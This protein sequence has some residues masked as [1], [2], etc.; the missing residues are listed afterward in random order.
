MLET[1][2]NAKHIQT[3]E[4]A[5][6]LSHL[7]QN[8][9][10]ADSCMIEAVD[11]EIGLEL[12]SITR[13]ATALLDPASAGDDEDSI[14]KWER[15]KCCTRLSLHTVTGMFGRGHHSFTAL[16]TCWL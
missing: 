10:L 13:S 5:S 3:P 4:A 12:D 7:F 15:G 6:K 16:R 11:G 1:N 9:S 2:A 8:S 14:M